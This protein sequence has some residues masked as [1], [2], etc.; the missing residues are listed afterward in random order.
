MEKKYVLPKGF[1][2]AGIEGQIKPGKIDTGLIFSETPCDCTAFFTKNKLKSAHILLDQ[3]RVNNK[4]R[5]VYANSGNA[6]AFTGNQ[7]IDNIVKIGKTVAKT[8]NVPENSVLFA[9]TGIIGKQLPVDVM[10]KN[11]PAVCAA[12]SAKDD[13]YPKAI[14][15]TDKFRKVRSA[16]LK[17]GNKTVTVSAVGKGAGMI[18]PDMATLLVFL[19]TDAVI[20]KKLLREAA[21]E[22]LEYSFNRITVDGDMSPNDT[23]MCLANGQAGNKKISSKGKDYT[24][25]KKAV[26]EAFYGIA[27]DMVSDGEGATKVV[28]VEIIN[29]RTKAA[30]KKAALRIA[31]SQLVKCAFFGESLNMGRI[32]SAIGQTGVDVDL[33]AISIDIGGCRAVEKG[34]LITGDALKKVLKQDKIHLLIDFKQGKE[35]HYILASDLTY[36]YV[37]ENADYS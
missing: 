11:A 13:N 25:F 30:A 28:K 2:S 34:K 6:N 8:L 35:K 31:N 37:R 21:K 1:K 9:A 3:K 23:V 17:L 36:D 26:S 18:S 16:A 22:A 12:L 4:I 33:N 27:E 24:A 32:L 15:T 19:M 10:V 7:G 20:D 5:A 14:M 29:S